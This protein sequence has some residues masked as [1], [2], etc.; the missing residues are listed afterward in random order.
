MSFGEVGCGEPETEK[1]VL[2]ENGPV[3]TNYQ[4]E[5]D[6]SPYK[7]EVFRSPVRSGVT[8]GFL[9][10]RF[11]GARIDATG[12]EVANLAYQGGATGPS[13]RPRPPRGTLSA[14]SRKNF[15]GS[16]GVLQAH[17]STGR[18]PAP[19]KRPWRGLAA[20]P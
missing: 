19:V 7:G 8:D 12:G 2:T 13:C 18:K 9:L 14:R 5:K 1:T 17:P 3:R 4:T 20:Q 16:K 15:W 11:V 6:L 10:E